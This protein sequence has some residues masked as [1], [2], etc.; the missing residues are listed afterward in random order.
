MILNTL[1]RATADQ[2][3]TIYAQTMSLRI[4]C[5]P[6]QV[7]VEGASSVYSG[8]CRRGVVD[9]E[10][11]AVRDQLDSLKGPCLENLLR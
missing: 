5:H 9:R 10:Y 3:A 2:R 7:E 4:T 1:A 6:E 11:T 8:A